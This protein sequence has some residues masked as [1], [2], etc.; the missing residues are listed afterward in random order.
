MTV[1]FFVF[2]DEEVFAQNVIV[3]INFLDK[4]LVLLELDAARLIKW[5]FGVFMVLAL[6]LA[7]IV[8]Y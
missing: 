7:H 8:L 4:M 5:K 2:R 1:G 6:A 3:V